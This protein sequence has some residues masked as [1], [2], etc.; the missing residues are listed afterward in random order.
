MRRSPSLLFGLSLI[1]CSSAPSSDDPS[2]ESEG[3]S[4]VG[5][6]D[7]VDDP[8]GTTSGDAADS[9]SS[10]GGEES[11]TTSEGDIDCDPLP[12]GSPPSVLVQGETLV[13]IDAQTLHA[14]LRFDVAAHTATGVAELTFALGPEGGM[15][16]FD[17]RQTITGVTL[18]G[19][20]LG[21][22]RAPF[23]QPSDDPAARMRAVTEALEPCSM[24]TL[25]IEY[26]VARPDADSSDA[27]LYDPAGV[28]WSSRHSDLWPGRYSEQ[29]W[30]S[31]LQ[32]DTVAMAIDVEL[33]EG[34]GEHVF[35]SNGEV[36]VVEDGHWHV[37]F[38]P[39]F[40]SLSPYAVLAP[41]ALVEVASADV[42]LP[43]GT[44]VTVDAIRL[45][46]YGELIEDI[47]AT[48]G[49]ALIAADLELGDYPH[50]SRF[51][52]Y[53][54]GLEG[55]MEY[56][57]ATGAMLGSIHHEVFHSWIARGMRPL[58]PRDGWFDETWTTYSVDLAFS[59]TPLAPDDPVELL[60][61]D[62]PW[63]RNTPSPAAYVT[64]PRVL[65]TVAAEI[66][67]DNLRGLLREFY[68]LHADELVTTEQLEE[69]LVC[70]TEGET[71]TVSFAR[72]VHGES[73][74][75]APTDRSNCP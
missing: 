4:E 39:D 71:V 2:E 74:P 28:I 47:L 26:E 23:F 30:P 37:E 70:A 64:G 33:V 5:T 22:D 72:W 9:S 66:G 8:A 6:T 10:A 69:F 68:Q 50:G 41:A 54:S 53:S 62:D 36:S 67:L 13:P 38:P 17:L 14:T 12:L 18:D 59:T 27:P 46:T 19:E 60:A 3:T 63:T 45:N 43:E 29:W 21:A 35:A 1:A 32:H 55:G 31:N 49:E 44:V 56:E 7:A 40:T 73:T 42:Q 20:D 16:I 11:S 25:T 57:G 34:A 65:A 48:T 15:P 24:H 52:V 51:L 75:A 58:R 61:S